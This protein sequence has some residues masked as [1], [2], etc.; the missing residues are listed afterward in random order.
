MIE[1]RIEKSGIY[2]A[3]R[4]RSDDESKDQSSIDVPHMVLL[5]QNLVSKRSG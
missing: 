2:R 5:C 4:N 3:I 1:A